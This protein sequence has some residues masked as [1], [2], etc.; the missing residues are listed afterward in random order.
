MFIFLKY[1][2]K[3]FCD[4]GIGHSQFHTLN[5]FCGK[6]VRRLNLFRQGAQ[7]IMS[8]RKKENIQSEKDYKT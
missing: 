8:R 5:S 2:M 1:L 3:F 6:Y 7:K 4:Y